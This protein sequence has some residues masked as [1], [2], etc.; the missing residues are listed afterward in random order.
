MAIT[1]D[2]NVKILN[3]CFELRPFHGLCK[4]HPDD[5][6]QPSAAN[7][8]EINEKRNDKCSSSEKNDR[9]SESDSG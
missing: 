5:I 9:I 1:I 6:L 7:S 3:D 4:P 2:V 8:Q